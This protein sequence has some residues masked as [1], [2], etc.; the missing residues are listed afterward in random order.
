[1]ADVRM[2]GFGARTSVA[3]AQAAIASRVTAL[4]TERIPFRV[5][6]HRVLAEDLI[7]PKNVPPHPR[8][9][10]DGYAVRSTDV[11]GTLSVSGEITAAQTFQGHVAQGQAVRIMT[12]AHVPDG[13]D[14][15][16]MVEET[17][18]DGDRVEIKARSSAGQHI[19]QTGEDLKQGAV[20]LRRGR[21]LRPEDVAMMIAIDALEI[22]VH[23]RP[24][25]RIVPTGSELVAPGTEAKGSEVVESNSF[26]L[27]GL[28]LRDGA[29]PV[30]HPIVPDQMDMLRRAIGDPGADLVVVTGGSSV[31]KEDFAP[32]VVR[33]L[34]ELPIHGI[35]VRPASPTGI[36]FI[37]KT[38]V[39]LAP[40]Y[41]VASYVAWDL[42]ARP[43]VQRMSG[44]EPH[45]PYRT[46]RASLAREHKKPASRVE[47]AR[48]VLDR[49][50]A[51]IIPGGAAL[52][53]TVTR[54]DGFV[55]LP[56]GRDVFPAGAELDVCL[57]GSD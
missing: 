43:I 46:V 33:E 28:A 50:V 7:A 52:L 57:Y 54:A 36:G 29:E 16:V 56:S 34:G 11:P 40:G 49:G 32:L 9:A 2:K 38:A 37:G 53:S 55:L 47:I 44:L 5:A 8:S 42:F 51:S 24:R 26:M 22:A 12:G 4:D 25:V 31:G 17:K 10:M 20:I 1:M 13:A 14:Q 18:L 35:D 27:E 6:L 15:V 21:K 3:D 41:P 30:L 23:K 39:V 19:L 48:V 45:L